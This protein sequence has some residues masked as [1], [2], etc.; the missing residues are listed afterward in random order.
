MTLDI[1]LLFSIIKHK[2]LIQNPFIKKFSL[3]L[4]KEEKLADMSIDQ[5]WKVTYW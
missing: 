3:I 4:C 1:F 5:T 2:T